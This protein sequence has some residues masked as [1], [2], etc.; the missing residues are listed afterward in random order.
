V[1]R[2]RKHTDRVDLAVLHLVR[3]VVGD[4]WA[5]HDAALALFDKIS[6][7][8]I[9]ERARAR[10]SLA[11]DERPG[12]YGKR[13]LATLDAALAL[14]AARGTAN[15]WELPTNEDFSAHPGAERARP[16]VGGAVKGGFGVDVAQRLLNRI[17]MAALVLAPL[18][19]EPGADGA[20]ARA[21]TDEL[22]ELVGDVQRSVFGRTEAPTAAV[23]RIDAALRRACG[24]LHNDW[25][26]QLEARPDQVMASR[27]AEV[28]RH[29]RAAAIELQST[30]PASR[31]PSE[32][33]TSPDALGPGGLASGPRGDSD[34]PST[35][36]VT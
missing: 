23:T 2:S 36:V 28:A 14:A 5:A 22:D 7:G 35:A 24:R 13:A 27:I 6:D 8:E 17:S 30:A 15:P 16:N 21:L 29:M 3:L 20:A 26:A 10:V 4:G 1:S 34:E 33:A 25:V 31:P 32:R 9:L 19:A 18:A 11:N 12:V